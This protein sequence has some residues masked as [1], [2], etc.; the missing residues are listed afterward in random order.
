MAKKIYVG[1]L[2]Y[3]T[4]EDTLNSLFAAIGPVVSAMIIKDKFTGHS[5]G[6]GFV[7]MENDD[8]VAKAI[9]ALNGKEVD[10]RP[11]RVNESIPQE[12]SFQRGGYSNRGGDRP[13]RRY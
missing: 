7:E 11:I 9:E 1:S 3:D 4:T 5:K 13:Q 12:K 6:F 8:D 2:S 10:G